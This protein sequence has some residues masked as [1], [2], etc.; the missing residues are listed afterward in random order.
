MQLTIVIPTFQLGSYLRG[1]LDDL[2]HQTQDFELWLVDDGS[3]DGTGKTVV[4]F[5]R[6]VPQFHAAVFPSHRGVSAARNY[7]L[8]RATGEAVAFLD[9]DDLIAPNFVEVLTSGFSAPDVVASS[10]G[11]NWYSRRGAGNRA[12][13]L[14]QRAMFE[15]VSHHGTEVGGYVWNKAF[16]RSAIEAAN[17]RFD[18]SLTLA[19]DYL[20]TAEFVAATPGRYAYQPAALYTKRNRP[21]STIHTA[22]WADRRGEDEVFAKMR[23]LGAHLK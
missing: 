1:M 12:M 22:S 19:E 21:G 15:Q 4:D 9:G 5:V 18:E 2:T 8:D 11:Y 13:M 10:V 3:T 17:L 14:D 20:F 23:A 6:G 7:G 16:R